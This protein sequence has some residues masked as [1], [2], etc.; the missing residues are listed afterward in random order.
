MAERVGIVS[1]AAYLP[2]YRL[3]RK[4]VAEGHGQPRAPGAIRPGPRPLTPDPRARGS[5]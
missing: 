2:R 3:A 4:L 5:R 1:A